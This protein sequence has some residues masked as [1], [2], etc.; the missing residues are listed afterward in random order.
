M[1][2]LTVVNRELIETE[3]LFETVTS[4]LSFIKTH[5]HYSDYYDDLLYDVTNYWQ[6]D[7]TQKEVF[8]LT[9]D[10]LTIEINYHKKAITDAD[11]FDKI[12]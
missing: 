4:V 7:T 2:T 12:L 8:F 9:N 5:K 11:M 3:L 1:F 6:R 10:E